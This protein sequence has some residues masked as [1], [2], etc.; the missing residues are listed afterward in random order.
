MDRPF[1][2]SVHRDALFCLSRLFRFATYR[3]FFFWQSISWL[4][5]C[6]QEIQV[7]HSFFFFRH[8]FAPGVCLNQIIYVLSTKPLSWHSWGRVFFCWKLD[9]SFWCSYPWHTTIKLILHRNFCWRDSDL[10]VQFCLYMYWGMVDG[11]GGLWD[12]IR[13]RSILFFFSF[14]HKGTQSWER[15][16]G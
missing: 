4:H 10:R 1:G 7:R 8:S 3:A 13:S 16:Q 2:F 15:V 6:S 12:L 9:L 5:R 14:R 11:G